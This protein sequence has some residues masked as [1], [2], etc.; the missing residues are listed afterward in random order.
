MRFLGGGF[1]FA[2]PFPDKPPGMHWQTYLRMRVAAGESIALYD[3][4]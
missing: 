3:Q 4:P 1:S 2:E